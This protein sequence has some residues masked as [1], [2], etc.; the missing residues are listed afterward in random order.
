MCLAGPPVLDDDRCPARGRELA[1]PEEQTA[2]HDVRRQLGE[3]PIEHEVDRDTTTHARPDG[4]LLDDVGLW[5]PFAAMAV[6]LSG[7][8][9][10]LLGLD[11]ER[12]RGDWDRQEVRK[13]GVWVTAAAPRRP[14]RCAAASAALTS[15][16]R[17]DWPRSAQDRSTALRLHSEARSARVPFGAV[18]PGAEARIASHRGSA[19]P[20]RPARFWSGGGDD[21]SG[22]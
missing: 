6:H 19:L 22:R 18:V 1:E 11:H 3:P 16:P 20:L 13:G 10:R 21:R 15:E 12:C 9:P 5:R 7:P 2:V 14:A 17:G 8:R 4:D